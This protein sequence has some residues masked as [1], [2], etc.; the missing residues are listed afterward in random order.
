MKRIL[1]FSFAALLA[2]GAPAFADEAPDAVATATPAAETPAAET[3]A[4]ARPAV[5]EAEVLVDGEPAVL[6]S[7]VDEIVQAQIA[8]MGAQFDPEASGFAGQI[9]RSVSRQLA[10]KYLLLRAIRAEGV[11][12]T[13]EDRAEFFKMATNGET[14]IARIAARVGLSP[15]RV[16]KE[17]EEQLLIAAKFRQFE[18][19]APA[20]E[21]IPEEE[22]A[23]FFAKG[24]EAQ[25][26]LTNA[27]PEQVRASHILVEARKGIATPEQDAAALEKIKKLRERALAGEDFGALARENSDCPSGKRA[28]GDLGPFGRG[29]M[30]PEFEKASF[31]QPVGE[32]GE[33]VKT[34]FGYHIIKVTEK[35]PAHVPTVEDF[36]P[37][38]VEAVRAQAAM[39]A[40]SEYIKSL[41]DA[42]KLEFVGE[43]VVSEPIAVPAPPAPEAPAAEPAAAE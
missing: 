38:I 11:R 41:R 9:R 22:I 33:V 18:K 37:Q 23:E 34:S 35:I 19:A 8:R 10:D 43:T 15:E 12:P 29:L 3:P 39:K 17:I 31:E 36:R 1:P 30:A 2:V 6:K 7:E 16:E 21:D 14:N 27:V 13:D 5:S 4:P 40:Q 25:P 42:A 26:Q 24:V 28:D 20:P 32:I